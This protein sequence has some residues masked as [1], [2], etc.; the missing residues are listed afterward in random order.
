MSSKKSNPGTKVST[1]SFSKLHTLLEANSYTLVGIFSDSEGDIHFLE[2]RTPKTQKTFFISIPSKYKMP[3]NEEAE[4]YKIMTITKSS[5]AAENRQLEYL[6]EIKGPLLT[7]DIIS[8]S[9]TFLCLYKHNK[10]AVIFKF[11]TEEPNEENQDQTEDEEDHVD[12]IIKTAGEISKKMGED[13]PIEEEIAENAIA[14]EVEEEIVEDAIV[15]A[16]GESPEETKVEDGAEEETPIELEFKDENGNIIEGDTQTL[17][18]TEPPITL[19]ESIE[20]EIKKL[21]AQAEEKSDESIVK[22]P[23][24]DRKR[25]ERKRNMPVPKN[26]Q[27]IDIS[28]GIVYI[29]FEIGVFNKKLSKNVPQD[30]NTV[31]KAVPDLEEEII[32]ICDTIDDNEAEQRNIRLDEILELSVKLAKKAKE[33]ILECEKEEMNL[34]TQIAKLSTVLEHCIKLRTKTETKPEKFSDVKPEIERLY[35]QTKTTLYE[36]NVELL[37]N[38]DRADDNL[39][40][41]QTSLEELLKF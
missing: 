1:L 11:G 30:K 29:S 18:E 28:I 8:I 38:K 9:S 4:R 10:D 22:S 25:E 40:R 21:E 14:D 3:V 15:V 5:D 39:N 37:R 32:D 33:E 24:L 12:K 23:E 36:M 13:I 19:P 31:K 26:I 16:E 27:E 6:T 35:K 41:Y 34:K 20:K 2:V 17:L 7:C